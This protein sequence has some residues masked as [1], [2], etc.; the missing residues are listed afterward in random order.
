[1]VCDQRWLQEKRPATPVKT[2]LLLCSIQRSIQALSPD[3][4][5]CRNRGLRDIGLLN[6]R[7]YLSRNEEVS[8]VIV[9]NHAGKPCRQEELDTKH[10][11]RSSSAS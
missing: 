3:L 1:M 5:D 9:G 8:I 11:I 6:T 7:W 2:G 4:S 10:W